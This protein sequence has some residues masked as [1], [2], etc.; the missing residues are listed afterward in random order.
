MVC[1]TRGGQ[2]NRWG[3]GV[4]SLFAVGRKVATAVIGA[5]IGATLIVAGAVS[6]AVAETP[7]PERIEFN[8]DIRPILAD[9]CFACHGPDSAKREAGLRL[10]TFEGASEKRDSGAA[11]VPRQAAA[12]QLFQRVTH[13]DEEL[14]MPPGS[15]GK[16]LEP[17]QVALLKR[18][19]EQG[20]EYQ[21]HWAYI[22]P[23]RTDPPTVPAGQ[24]VVNP[25]DQFVLA[26]LAAE[27][28]EP[29]A[30]ADRRT[31]A[32]RLSFDL[33]GLPPSPEEVAAFEADRSPRAY[34]NFVDRLFASPH[35]A[36][37]MAV[38]WLDVV[39][40]AD[41][42]GYHSDNHRDL[43]PYRDYVVQ[44]FHKNKPF[45]QFAVEQL[46]GDLLPQPT[47]ES[48]IASGFNR[49]LQT[50]E[51][52][53]SQAREYTAKYA[54][55]RV[56]NA[57]VIWMG[58]TLGCSECH[59]HKF[60]PFSIKDFYS[61]QAFFADVAERAVGRQE[62]TPIPTPDQ[63][64]QLAELD[65]RLKTLRSTL[66]ADSPEL[67]ADQA[68]WEARMVAELAAMK[69]TWTP[70]KP[71]SVVSSGG[72]KFETLDD[73]SVLG[74]GENPDLDTYTI[75]LA[76]GESRVTGVR[77]EVLTHPSLVNQGL[78]RANGN[79]VLSEIE[80]DWVAGP[81]AKPERLEVKRAEADFSQ[82][83]HPIA[84]AIDRNATTGWAVDGHQKPADHKAVF[85]FA[86]PREPAP[87]AKLVV[88][89]RH[90]SQFP[91]HTVGRFRLAV[92]GIDEP[93]ISDVALPAAIVDA[94]KVPSADRT[95][96]QRD[97]LK[98]HY[99]GLAPRL[100][101]VRRELAEAE[102]QRDSL[103]KSF[104]QT[105]ITTAV[106]PRVIRVLPRGNW[107]DESGEIVEPAVPASLNPLGV[108]GR[109]A[110]RL[111]LAR[112]LVAQDNPLTARV[113]V[114]R[115]WKL[116]FG[117]GI[118]RTVEDLGTQGELP[119]HPE[120]L[121]WL[122][123]EFREN[124]WD[125]KRL[126]KLM[127]MSATYRQSSQS[128]AP[129]AARARE[130]DPN[131]RL[132]SRQNRFRLDAE[133]VRDNALA[134]S[135]LLSRR[136]GGPSVKPYQPAGYWVNLNFPRREWQND[137]GEDLYRRGLYTYWCRTFLHPSL[138]A[139][140][141]PSR[142]E[143]VAERPRSNTPLQALV[144]LND[145]TYV[146]AARALAARV[147]TPPAGAA[148][149]GPESL[150]DDLSRFTFLFQRAVQRAPRADETRLLADLLKQ[151]RD[152]FQANAA[153][154]QEL[155]KVGAA[156]IPPGIPAAELAAWTSVA[157]AVMNLHETV[158][159]N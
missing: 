17:R 23:R 16:S 144:L 15:T 51:E 49:L 90:E 105:L 154:A 153:A 139:F 6:H 50:T 98:Q 124:G 30:E 79:F 60:D 94:L 121:D 134:I 13:T 53:G 96:A 38:Y 106:A 78:S 14:R 100:D 7:L 36:E 2:A 138:A 148:A 40:Y 142:E 8:R 28:L 149:S 20:A 1:D 152:H 11:I 59:N 75:E 77:L 32:R 10:D 33:L 141:A 48:R 99:R 43:A 37:R 108:E 117:Q 118:V 126:H 27:Q 18:W 46:A 146:E 52:G 68:A 128:A 114:N 157:R 82:A 159:R 64:R 24:S 9:K 61:M 69:S 21:S 65:E 45:D 119:S 66:T 19:I 102:K 91:K 80:F 150:A 147:L 101:P 109:R 42:A 92:S 26:R 104:P 25:I 111:D 72:Q 123:V 116:T 70:L 97:A 155:L 125:I 47:N 57:S 112:W 5:A 54:A 74:G 131:N 107:L 34:E 62:Q 4:G 151:H 86:N 89:M 127:V 135:G 137:Q 130:V 41:T 63:E 93:T 55:D 29:A 122:A 73:L 84:A 22:A 129:T 132:L 39:R 88:R 110:T 85:A 83:N 67:S 145:P 133:F 156:P 95:A 136:V 143:C 103:V 87:N 44:A 76:P 71:A 120:L 58:V 158:T 3:A 56:R 140:D 31:L 35:Y 113:F 12:S 81:D 115:V